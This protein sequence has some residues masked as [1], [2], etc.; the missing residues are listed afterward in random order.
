MKV[1][2]TAFLPYVIL[3][4]VAWYDKRG[5]RKLINALVEKG[6]PVVA[7]FLTGR[8]MWINDVLNQSDAFVVSWLPGTQGEGIADVLLRDANDAVQFDLVWSG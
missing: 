2:S 3:Y 7:V 6:I 5:E 8:P 4:T 1:F